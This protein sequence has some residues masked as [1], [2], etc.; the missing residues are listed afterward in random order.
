M[1]VFIDE[2]GDAGLGVDASPVFVVAMVIFADDAA[3]AETQAAI[4]TSD[5]RRRHTHEF[6]F[7]KCRDDARDGFFAAV[8]DCPFSV[9]AVVVEKGRA[10]SPDLVAS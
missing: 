9:R 4:E 10:R 6:K 5:V 8:R 7:S 2:S 1:L 3:A